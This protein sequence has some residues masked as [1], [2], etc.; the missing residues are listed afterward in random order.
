[1]TELLCIVG[2]TAV[3]KSALAVEI[4]KTSGAEIISADASQIYQGLDIGTG[5][6]TEAEAEGVPHHLIDVAPPDAPFDAQRFADLADAAIADIT[7]RGR[8]V[9]VCGGTGLYFRALVD[10]LC[11]TP[12]VS[13]AVKAELA[14]A[15]EAGELTALH[16]E[17]AQVDP[18]AAARIAP[19][20]RQRIERAL[21]VYRSSGK[22]LSDWQAEHRE[23]PKRYAAQW[24][25]L[26]LP[27]DQLNAR[28][29]ARTRAMYDQ[30]LVDEVAR[31][32]EA[33][34]GPALKSMGAIGYR[35]AALV[36]GGRMPLETAIEL[37]ARDTRRYAKRQMTWFKAIE[38]VQWIA[39]P[40]SGPG[41]AS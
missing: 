39:P 9:I 38:G 21:G 26:E 22:A 2:P 20:D 4:A 7:G 24:L 17:L 15:I 35:Y 13:E 25:G 14:A 29:D 8:P 19:A 1:M 41:G 30:G 10:G 37:T 36:H 23:A 18:E 32:V 27:R 28:I 31:L 33:G 5:K 6:I 12:P 16:R 3:G 40:P 34:Y 11:P